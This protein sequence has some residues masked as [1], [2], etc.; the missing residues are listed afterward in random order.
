MAG[1]AVLI[2]PSP[3]EFPANR[4][5]YRENCILWLPETIA[6]S[7]IAEHQALFRQFP[8]PNYQGNLFEEQRIFRT[9]TAIAP[10]KRHVRT[11]LV[12]R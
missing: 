3:A 11:V 7:Q 9:P 4:E 8:Y 10:D 12:A 6:K 1:D 2:A 5:F